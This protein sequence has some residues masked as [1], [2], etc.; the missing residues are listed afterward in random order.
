[1]II[2]NKSVGAR[3]PCYVIAEIGSNHCQDLDLALD[4]IS[5][6]AE[7]GAD[8][9]KFQSIKFDQ[10]YAPV[11]A[12]S[13]LRDWFKF[14]ELNESWYPK[15]FDRA[16]SEGL[17]FLSSPTYQG[18]IDLLVGLGVPA[19]KLASPQVQGNLPLVKKAAESGLPLILSLG[20]AD[21]GDIQRAVRCCQDAG[22][23]DLILLHCISAYPSQP[24]DARLRFI[25]TLKSMTGLP[26]GFSDHTLGYHLPLAAVALGA[27]VL[28]KHVTV[29]R[30][31]DGPDHHFSL[32]FKEFSEMV[33]RIREVESAL[34]DG[35][36]MHLLPE[37]MALRQSVGMKA[38]ISKEIKKGT[39][40]DETCVAFLRSERTG[41][42]ID[43]LG[44]LGRYKARKDLSRGV[45]IQWVDIQ[46]V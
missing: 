23:G 15:L 44:S 30:N 34:G 11:E 4:M 46:L 12:S 36:R 13:E 1:M 26:V 45:V 17:A 14:I 37:E 22:N 10:L 25:P 5:M 2:R 24:K 7:A 33:A 39:I 27:T 18:A 40:L 38:I 3:E 19:L 43:A 31:A 21:Y 16:E 32:T 41:L 20:Y 29:S 6:A 35:T 28:E 42:S 8:A 9:V